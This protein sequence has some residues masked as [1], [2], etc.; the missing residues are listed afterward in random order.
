MAPTFARPN[1][2]ESASHTKR[3][4]DTTC[5][6]H[7]CDRSAR[8]PLDCGSVKTILIHDGNI[9]GL[10]R[11]RSKRNNQLIYGRPFIAQSGQPRPQYPSSS[12]MIVRLGR[13]SRQRHSCNPRDY[14]SPQV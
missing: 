6:C 1:M 12:A 10:L 3:L 11:G 9:D 2:L 5:Q 13:T 8:E 7:E 14:P 4:V